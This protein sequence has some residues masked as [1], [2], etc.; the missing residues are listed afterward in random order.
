M[1]MSNIQGNT[2][3]GQSGALSNDLEVLLAIQSASNKYSIPY[4]VL[5][6]LC[7]CESGLKQNAIGDSGKA[8]GI[9]QW[10]LTSWNYYNG[11]YQTDLD[12]NNIYDQVEMTARVLKD[13]G[14]NNWYNCFK[15]KVSADLI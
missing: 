3:V 9:Y 12:R 15:Y 5:Y 11:V 8:V 13:G 2:L 7:E 4:S 14:H 1:T 10:W 6:D